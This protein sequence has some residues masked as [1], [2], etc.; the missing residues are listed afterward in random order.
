MLLVY[1]KSSR[2]I[3]KIYILKSTD[4][5]LI[6]VHPDPGILDKSL[7]LLQ[8]PLSCQPLRLSPSDTHISLLE[9]FSFIVSVQPF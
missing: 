5:R 1:K 4:L 6:P 9:N 7:G 3:S 8:Q 2:R